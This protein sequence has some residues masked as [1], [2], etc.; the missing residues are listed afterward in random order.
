MRGLFEC[1]GRRFELFGVIL[2][3]PLE[4]IDSIQPIRRRSK[5][6]RVI[7]DCEC[8]VIQML[9]ELQLSELKEPRSQGR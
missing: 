3:V 4:L 5:L 7:Q 2:G 8:F 6:S 1:P 9:F